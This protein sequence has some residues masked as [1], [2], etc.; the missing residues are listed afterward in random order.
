MFSA[1][2][3][4]TSPA[5]AFAAADGHDAELCHPGAERRLGPRQC[6]AIRYAATP[7]ALLRTTSARLCAR[8]DVY[9]ERRHGHAFQLFPIRA[10]LLRIPCSSSN[11]TRSTP[12]ATPIRTA[13][14]PI[15]INVVLINRHAFCIQL[16]ACQQSAATAHT[17]AVTVTAPSRRYW[18]GSPRTRLFV[19]FLISESRSNQISG[20]CS[21]Y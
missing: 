19:V 18:Y 21:F 16:S 17:A 8:P 10:Q 9:V 12:A 13:A 5:A 15:A 7:N 20:N 2:R 6:C 11:P 1:C 14:P 3:S 4:E